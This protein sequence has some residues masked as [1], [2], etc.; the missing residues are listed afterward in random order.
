MLERVDLRRQVAKVINMIGTE[1]YEFM[2]EYNSRK[3]KEV[4]DRQRYCRLLKKVRDAV[5]KSI[6]KR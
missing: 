6:P 5:T 1:D 2:V 3:D 4:C